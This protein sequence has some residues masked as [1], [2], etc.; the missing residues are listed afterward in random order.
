MLFR[1]IETKEI[2]DDQDYSV[3]KENLLKIMKNNEPYKLSQLKISGND[4]KAFGFTGKEVGIVLNKLLLAVL[5]DYR[6][7]N[8]DKLLSLLIQIRVI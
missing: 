7:N 3:T 4:V 5:A 6:L 2:I 8:R 1:S